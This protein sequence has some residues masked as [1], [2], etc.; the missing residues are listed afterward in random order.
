MIYWLDLWRGLFS[1]KI[2]CRSSDDSVC[3]L[4]KINVFVYDR[5]NLTQFKR[6]YKGTKK[7]WCEAQLVRSGTHCTAMADPKDRNVS[8]RLFTFVSKDAQEGKPYEYNKHP[9][10][11]FNP[12][13][14]AFAY[15]DNVLQTERLRVFAHQGALFGKRISPEGQIVECQDLTT[16]D[17][18]FAFIYGRYRL[19]IFAMPSEDGQLLRGI[20]QGRNYWELRLVL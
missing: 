1:N 11:N 12:F 7:I 8:N 13:A 19:S 4:T 6:D 20:V 14:V 2:V 17:W 16:V 9:I 5:R 10:P 3:F 15:S 18:L